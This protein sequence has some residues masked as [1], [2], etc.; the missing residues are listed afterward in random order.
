VRPMT[1]QHMIDAFGGE[2]M[3]HLRYSLFAAQAD[4]DGFPNVARLFRAVSN[5]EFIHAGDHY[6]EL[7][8]LDEGKVA[9][10]MGAFGPGD[11]AK[12]LGLAVAGETFEVDEMYPA[13]LAVA[14]LEGEKGA[15]RSFDWSY[16]TEKQH[17]A[18][19]Q[20][21]KA[22]VD[23]GGDVALG[24]VQVCLTCGYTLEGEAPDQCPVCK[25]KADK[26][27]AFAE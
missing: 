22:A 5:A 14:E 26:F 9:H 21:A 20:K 6:R 2:S 4:K 24:T 12:N 27:T 1:Q 3:A 25:A 7:R 19:Y 8:H 18:L 16:Q 17:L 11:T 13:Y 23:A 10:S 15:L